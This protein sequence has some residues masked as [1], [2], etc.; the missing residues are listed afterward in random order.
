M[1][2]SYYD[3]L[4]D[5]TLRHTD[6]HWIGDRSHEHRNLCGQEFNEDAAVG[7]TWGYATEDE[8]IWICPACLAEEREHCRWKVLE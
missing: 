6:F 5:L 3:G 4:F 8:R 2:D 7:L 1:T